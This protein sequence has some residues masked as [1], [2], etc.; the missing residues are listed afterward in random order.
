MNRKIELNF[1]LSPVRKTDDTRDTQCA[2]DGRLTA[3]KKN[4]GMRD[5]SSFSQIEMSHTMQTKHI[6][7]LSI[8]PLVSH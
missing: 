8:R 4:K 7:R 2:F 3:L 5:A 6:S 1:E